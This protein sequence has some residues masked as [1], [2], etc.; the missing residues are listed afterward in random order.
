[1]RTCSL[2]LGALIAAGHRGSTG[3]VHKPL[4]ALP[5]SGGR[6]AGWVVSAGLL[7]GMPMPVPSVL[8]AT[9]GLTMLESTEAQRIFSKARQCESDGNFK[10]AQGFYEQVVEAEPNFIYAWANLANALVSQGNLD[11]ALLCYKKAI[12]LQP[13]R[14]QLGLIVLNRASVEMSLNMNEAAIRDL[15]AAEKLSGST[16]EIVTTR[17][18]ALTNEGDWSAA[19]AL[20]ERIISTSDKDALPWWLR[21]SES[22]LETSRGTEAVAFLQRTLNR[23]PYED[24]CKAFAVALYSSLGTK[25]ESQRYWGQM[26]EATRAKYSEPAFYT[27]TLKWGPKT[28]A[29]FSSFLSSKYASVPVPSSPLKS[30]L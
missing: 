9:Q 11:Q 21:Y 28:I 27:K 13:P 18:V 23:F 6:L 22:L 4:L 30:E 2:L 1:M 8:A 12:T 19:V 15:A 14:D 16:P 17:A 10:A 26:D 24:D 29:G 25:V 20:F 3:S 5:L 7:S